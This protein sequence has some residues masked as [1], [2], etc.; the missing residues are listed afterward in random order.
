MANACTDATARVVEDMQASLPEGVLLRRIDEDRPGLSNARNRGLEEARSELVAYV[1]DD[2]EV[3]DGW[4]DAIPRAFS[5]SPKVAVVGGPVFPL[6]PTERAPLW[7][8]ASIQGFFTILDYGSEARR[9][10]AA[11]EWLAGTNIAFRR[12]RLLST[13]GFST[14]LGRM[15][16]LLLSNEEADATQRIAALGDEVWYCPAMRVHHHVHQD[17]VAR[18]W[19]LRRAFWQGIS[20][21][22]LEHPSAVMVPVWPDDPEVNRLLML[23]MGFDLLQEFLSHDVL[24]RRS[25]MPRLAMKAMSLGVR[26]VNVKGIFL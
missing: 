24:R 20:N 26:Y 21:R 18:R 25:R 7:L 13:G 5:L 12:S 22:L 10:T 14:R 16:G 1:D 2:A 15:G 3:Q 8:D 9:L 17:R 6:W 4:L 23:F 11:H 19:L